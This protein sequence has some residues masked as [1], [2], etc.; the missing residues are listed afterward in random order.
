MAPEQVAL[1]VVGSVVPVEVEARLPDGADLG[2]LRL[3][4]ETVEIP[5]RGRL[6]VVRV[7]A[8]GHEDPRIRLAHRENAGP[9]RGC[10]V[11]LDQKAAARRPDAI[12]DRRAVLVECP[13]VNVGM[14]VD[15]ASSSAMWQPPQPPPSG[16]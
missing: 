2:K 6:A 11:D 13:R 5:R 15:Q 12:D 14:G 3:R 10:D 16:S 9:V 7:D 1:D 4:K 8:D